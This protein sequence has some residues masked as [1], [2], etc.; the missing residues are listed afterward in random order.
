MSYNRKQFDKQK[1]KK[2]ADECSG[3]C[4][5]CY[6]STYRNRY[7]RFWKSRGRT[8]NYALYK[9]FARRKCRR[10]AK[11]FDFYSKKFDDPRWHA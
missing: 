8:S 5:G 10:Y 9:K 1:L 2:L 6:Y 3:W 11:K 7:I 4:G